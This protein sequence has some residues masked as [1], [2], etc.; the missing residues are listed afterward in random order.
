MPVPDGISLERN[1]DLRGRGRS[2]WYRRALLAAI[3]VLPALALVNFFGQHPVTSSAASPAVAFDV[4]A[5]ERLRGGL[6]FQVR[7]QVRA[8][9]AISDLR[10]LFDRGWFESMSVNAVVPEPSEERSQDGRV[11]L[12]YGSL[13]A[14]RTLTA[15]LY[16]QVN[17]TNVAERR[18]DVSVADGQ[19]VLATVH[20]STTIFP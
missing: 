20:R 8:R 19:T 18:E 13:A 2:P 7:V 6:I 4:T 9:R 12:D 16:F 15:W 3:A 1:R 14:G 11:A 17:P 5:P 10:V